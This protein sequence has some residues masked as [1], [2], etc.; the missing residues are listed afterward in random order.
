MPLL[1]LGI[2]Y[3][4]AGVVATAAELIIRTS[5]K[6]QMRSWDELGLY[7]AGFTLIVSYARIV[8]VA[9]DADFYPR[10]SAAV[11]NGVRTR[12]LISRQTNVLVMLMTPLLILFALS[13]PLLIPILLTTEFLPVM[14]MVVCG[15]AFMFFKAIYTPAASL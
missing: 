1:R 8:F 7:T 12:T 2:S 11:H 3:V 4:L 14:P 5:L 13:L 15:L 6:N 9:M 10:L